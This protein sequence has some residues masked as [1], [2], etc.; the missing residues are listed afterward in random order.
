MMNYEP[1]GSTKSMTNNTK[2]GAKVR[3]IFYPAVVKIH[4]TAVVKIDYKKYFSSP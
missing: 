4:H 2:Y 3:N 1:E